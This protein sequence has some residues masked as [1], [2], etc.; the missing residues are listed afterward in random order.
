METEG[1]VSLRAPRLELLDVSRKKVSSSSAANVIPM[2]ESD[3]HEELQMSLSLESALRST[4]WRRERKTEVILQ[5]MW[6][7]IAH[8]RSTCSR[9]FISDSFT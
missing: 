3:R 5:M 8:V 1:Y 2:H 6:G 4:T 9:L 7:V